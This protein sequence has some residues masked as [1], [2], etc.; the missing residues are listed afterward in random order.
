MLLENCPAVIL[1]GGRGTRMG[2]LCDDKPK[3]LV[4]VQGRPILW[5]A[6]WSLFM[7]GFKQIILPLGYRGQQIVDYLHAE[8]AGHDLAI[9]AVDTGDSTPIGGRLQQISSLLPHGGDFFLVNGDTIFDFDIQGMANLHKHYTSALVTMSSV[10]LPAPFG[11]IIE[12]GGHVVDFGRGSNVWQVRRGVD[13]ASNNECGYVNAGLTW[14]SKPA[15]S[16]IDLKQCEDFEGSLY[17]LMARKGYCSL[18]QIKETWITVNNVADLEVANKD[19]CVTALRDKI[20]AQV[21]Q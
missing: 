12:Q 16:F 15:L 1:C 2:A 8:F 20:L 11:I 18:F 9:E 4:E 19:Q 13:D 7:R 10:I 5:Y 17:S 14:I 21:Q 3:A 6:I